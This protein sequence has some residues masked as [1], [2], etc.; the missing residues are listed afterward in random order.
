MEKLLKKVL[1]SRLPVRHALEKLPSWRGVLN[2]WVV[3]KAAVAA[4]ASAEFWMKK[5]F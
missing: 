5:R 4:G 2:V 3:K 1:L